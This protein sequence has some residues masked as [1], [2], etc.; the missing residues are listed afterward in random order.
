M[1][2]E[3]TEAQRQFMQAYE[4]DIEKIKEIDDLYGN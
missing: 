2:E 4:E 3:E 1:F